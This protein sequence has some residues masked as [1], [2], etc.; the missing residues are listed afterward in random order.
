MQRH[1]FGLAPIALAISLIGAAHAQQ[2]DNPAPAPAPP[3]ANPPA[4]ASAPLAPAVV[5]ATRTPRATLDVP[6]SVD[7]VNAAQMQDAELRENLSES[8][9]RVPGL[10][11]LNRLNYAQDLQLSIRGFGARSTFGERGVRL[12]VDGVPANFPDGQG[13]V[14][15]FPISA[16]DHIEVL[17]G[18]FSALYGNSS[19]GVVALT[20]DLKPQPVVLDPSF[21]YGS[22][23][24]WR[25]GFNAKG[26]EGTNA[27]NIDADRFRTSGYR[28]HDA[29]QR[30]TTNIAALLGDTPLGS[31]HVFLNAIYMPSAQDAMGL[32]RAQWQ[33]NPQAASP[34][35]LQFD[36][37]KSTRQETAGANLVSNLTTD[38]QL[39]SSAWIGSRGVTQYQAIPVSTQLAPTSPGGVISF[40]RDFGGADV[41]LS[42]TFQNWW[43]TTGGIDVER[44]NERRLGF[45]NFIGPGA[46]PVELGVEGALR[47]RLLNTVDSVDPYLQTELRLGSS[48]IVDA[49]VRSSRVDIA[50]NDDLRGT[51]SGI[52]YSGVEPT[53]GVV[54]KLTPAMSLYAS[55]GRGFETPTLTELAYR[56]S[57]LPGLN[58]SLQAARS[59]NGE[60]G[61]KGIVPQARV[62][63]ALAFYAVSTRNDLVVATNSGGRSTY[64]NVGRDRRTGGEAE[65][66]WAISP[67]WSAALSMQTINAHFSTAYFTC[68]SAPC[69][70]PTLPVAAGN[71][72]PGIPARTLY[73]EMKYHPG[74]ADLSLEAHAASKIYVDDRN[75]DTAPGY[76]IADFSIA[77]TFVV[78]RYKPR[79][80][81]RVDNIL[82]HEYVGSVIVNESNSRFFEPSPTRTYLVGIDFPL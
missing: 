14:S 25:V 32:T 74:W 20:T 28:D 39:T 59:D 79:V 6:A 53:A 34:A 43:T 70:T 24:T 36:S 69:T 23:S 8:L 1:L 33:A 42:Y 10:V 18:P 49:G 64:N 26:G 71:K 77:R 81:G 22:Y 46:A 60:I 13:Q 31:L 62:T 41:R 29:A 54:Y 51:S 30:D 19:G 27:F 16:A 73:A 5:T 44:E 61:L 2:A 45:N 35:A 3:Q 82:N 48:W 72:L 21:S 76:A 80:F 65:V 63:Y 68:V 11:I 78:G 75:T 57:G 38:L 7:I 15:H 17:R 4:D 52:N 47:Q 66:D 56:P 37:R 12:Y 58:T 55:F 50:S 9:G 40:D 67:M